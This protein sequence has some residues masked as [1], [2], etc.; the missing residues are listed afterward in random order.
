MER[1]AVLVM[2]A[3][4]LLYAASTLSEVYRNHKWQ[5]EVDFRAY[6]ATAL[7]AGRGGDIYGHHR[8]GD[9]HLRTTPYTY[10]PLLACLLFPLAKLT[11]ALGYYLWCGLMLVT[12][13]I[14]LLLTKRSVAVLGVGRP[15]LLAV[16]PLLLCPFVLDSNLYWGQVN[17]LVTALLAGAVL[18]GLRNRS[19]AAGSLIALAAAL[20][21]LPVLAMLWFVLHRDYR[22]L[23]GFFVTSIVALFFIPALVGGPGWAWD[24]NL[25][26]ATLMHGVL[27]EGR[28]GLQSYYTGLQ[29]GSLVATFDRLF[30]GSGEKSLVVSLTQHRIDGMVRLIR[31]TL[32]AASV[33]ALA[34]VTLWRH[35][36]SLKPQLWVMALSLL[37][38]TGWLMNYLLWDHHLV[39]L[40]IMLPLL[41]GSRRWGVQLVCLFVLWGS[42]FWALVTVHRVGAHGPRPGEQLR[43][44]LDT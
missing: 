13:W 41:P 14:A 9:N 12:L 7:A 43:L 34:R 38:I 22:A 19:A 25:A 10:P 26:Y 42:L 33:A 20:K 37:T 39:G 40:L 32:V 31:L 5:P 21:V 11:L 24:T 4:L 17:V 23:A 35:R 15:G 16:A 6:R 1:V 8:S 30:G 44:P 18:M 3:L 2:A 36:D 28:A 27:T 29:N